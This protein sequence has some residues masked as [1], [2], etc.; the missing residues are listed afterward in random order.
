MKID[1]AVKAQFWCAAKDFHWACHRATHVDEGRVSPEMQQ[2]FD[3]LW[4][5]VEAAWV[6]ASPEFIL[7]ARIRLDI[8]RL[9]VSKLA[10]DKHRVLHLKEALRQFHLAETRKC[11]ADGKD[12]PLLLESAYKEWCEAAKNPRST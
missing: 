5:L 3:R 7:V 8:K 12:C 6:V 4:E 9:E 11:L 2:A 10:A 1:D